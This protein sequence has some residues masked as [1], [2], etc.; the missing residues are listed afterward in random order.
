MERDAVLSPCGRYRYR[1]DR[2]VALSGPVYAFF[3]INPSKADDTVDDAT[4]RK[5]IGFTT[6]W[7]GSR[8]VVGNVF[9][10]RATDVRELAL[11]ADPFG[12]D[13]E[14]HLAEIILEADILVPCWG[15]LNKIPPRLQFACHALAQSLFDSG[16]P[17]M[18]FGTTRD[19][20]PKHPLMLGYNTSLYHWSCGL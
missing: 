10:Y 13:R 5:W 19:G 17:V 16:K 6:R 15:S 8:F 12:L 2:R 14:E 3:G 7:G 9:A 1:L 11:A 18:T 20:D 4:V